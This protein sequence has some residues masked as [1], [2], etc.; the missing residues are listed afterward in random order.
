[1]SSV[2]DYAD[3]IDAVFLL[4][5]QNVRLQLQKGVKKIQSRQ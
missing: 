1:M 2:S 5:F 3:L 4:T